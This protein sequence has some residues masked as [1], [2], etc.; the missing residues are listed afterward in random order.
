MEDKKNC[1]VGSD[2]KAEKR[3]K[4]VAASVKELNNNAPYDKLNPSAVK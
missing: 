4:D 3:E 1:K 2:T